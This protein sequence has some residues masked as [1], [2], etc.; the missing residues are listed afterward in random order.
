M[1]AI[2]YAGRHVADRMHANRLVAISTAAS[3]NVEFAME[4]FKLLPAKTWAAAPATRDNA[5]A[6]TLLHNNPT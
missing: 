1:L 4:W 2:K 6:H 5:P 3:E